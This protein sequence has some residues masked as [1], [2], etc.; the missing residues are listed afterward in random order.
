MKK[1][2]LINAVSEQIGLSQAQSKRAVN[3]IINTMAVGL[4]AGDYV[5]I[6]GFGRLSVVFRAARRYRNPRTKELH[7]IP[8]CKTV[9]FNPGKALKVS[10]NL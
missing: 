8:A 4:T 6:T 7:N 9:R 1:I 3:T 5:A 10:I 2:D